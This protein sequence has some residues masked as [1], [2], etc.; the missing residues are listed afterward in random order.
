MW[1]HCYRACVFAYELEKSVTSHRRP[2]H[3]RGTGQRERQVPGQGTR[4]STQQ[5]HKRGFKEVLKNKQHGMIP[6]IAFVHVC[7]FIRR[8][9][10]AWAP[11]HLAEGPCSAS[12]ANPVL[13]SILQ[14]HFFIQSKNICPKLFYCFC[15]LIIPLMSKPVATAN[16]LPPPR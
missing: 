8:W 13:P 10:K 7:A 3:E 4:I 5:D 15:I 1:R 11:G 2:E 14:K 9:A 6:S 16:S 12:P